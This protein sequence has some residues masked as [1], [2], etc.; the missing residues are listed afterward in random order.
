ME[1]EHQQSEKVGAKLYV[2]GGRESDQFWLP[3]GRSYSRKPFCL[4]NIQEF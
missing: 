2:Y 4:S 1:P 3:D